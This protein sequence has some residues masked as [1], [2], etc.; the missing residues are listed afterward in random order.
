LKKGSAAQLY[1]WYTKADYRDK[2]QK[3]LDN[4]PFCQHGRW[5]QD[6]GGAVYSLFTGYTL[7]KIGLLSGP[8]TGNEEYCEAPKWLAATLDFAVAELPIIVEMKCPQVF[9][10]DWKQRYWVQCQQQMQLSRVNCLH[11]VQYIPPTKLEHGQMTIN[12]IQ[13]NNKWFISVLPQFSKFWKMVE[14]DRE[15]NKKK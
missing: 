12:E 8:R 15:V 9:H 2:E 7:V 13:Y 14:D 11:L 1:R 5:F 10:D 6:E 3:K 4:N